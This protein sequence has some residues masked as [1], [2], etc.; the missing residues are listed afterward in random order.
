MVKSCAICAEN[1]RAN[2][3]EAFEPHKLSDY[4]M[5]NIHMDIFH[6]NGIDYLVTVDAYTKWL[7]CYKMK[8]SRSS[9]IIDI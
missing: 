6:L 5:Q 1:S 4:L 3:S 2:N 8:T 9:E 7:A